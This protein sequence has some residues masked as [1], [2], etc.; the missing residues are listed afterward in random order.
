VAQYR[1]LFSPIRYTSLPL[2]VVEGLT[3]GMPIVALA[4]TELPT[5]IENGK[6]GY[7]SC[8]IDELVEHMRFLLAQPG[9]ARRMSE[10]ARKLAQERF[11]I[12]RFARDWNNAFATVTS[13]RFA[14]TAPYKR[15][16]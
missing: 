12:E 13:E 1:F 2:A 6:Q 14:S 16:P 4:T 7:L 11:H 10:Q 9:E 3:I 8:N 15:K 5:V